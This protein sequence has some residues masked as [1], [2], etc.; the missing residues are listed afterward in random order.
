MGKKKMLLGVTGTIGAINLPQFIYTLRD[1]YDIDVIL[2]ENAQ[3]FLSPRAIRPFVQ[4]VYENVFSD[5]SSK[6][7][8]VEL[9]NEIDRFLILPTSAATLSKIANGAANDLLSLS[10]L[11]Y[12]EAI[13]IAPNMNNEMWNNPAVQKNVKIIKEFGHIFVNTTSLGI[14]ASS[15]EIVQ[16][17]AGLPDPDELLKLLS[18]KGTVLSKS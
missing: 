15:G 14:K 3:R 13:Y 2:T 7:L 8:H 1:E 6:I 16:T 4:G 5:C 17:E 11:N 12:S 18:E 10:V 9:V